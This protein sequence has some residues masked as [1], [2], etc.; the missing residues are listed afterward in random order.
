MNHAPTNRRTNPLHRFTVEPLIR[1]GRSTSVVA[2]ATVTEAATSRVAKTT[3]TVANAQM[4]WVV[5]TVRD[6]AARPASKGPVHPK[7]ASRYPKP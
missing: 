3:A 2:V 1:I 7:P 6:W 5:F 4:V